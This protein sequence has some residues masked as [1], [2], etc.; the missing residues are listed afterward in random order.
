MAARETIAVLSMAQDQKP[1][2]VSMCVCQSVLQ[3]SLCHLFI[4]VQD[5]DLPHYADPAPSIG[6]GIAAYYLAS[7]GRMITVSPTQVYGCNL[8]DLELL[9]AQR[10]EGEQRFD[11]LEVGGLDDRDPRLPA[12]NRSHMMCSAPWRGRTNCSC[13]DPRPTCCV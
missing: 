6:F 11:D 12:Q 10:P 7:T 2:S 3:N 1:L 4:P 9:A 8:S 13:D 5:V